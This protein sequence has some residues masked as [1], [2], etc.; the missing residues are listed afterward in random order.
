MVAA[1]KF[2]DRTLVLCFAGDWAQDGLAEIEEVVIEEGADGPGLQ[3]RITR[4]F[5]GRFLRPLPWQEQIEKWAAQNVGLAW[6]E[7]LHASEVLELWRLSL[8][9]TDPPARKD[10]RWNLLGVFV[11]VCVCPY[12]Y[13]YICIYV[14]MCVCACVTIGKMCLFFLG[15]Q[16][17][18]V[19]NELN[20]YMYIYVYVHLYACVCTT[21]TFFLF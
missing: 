10:T 15:F 19:A 7:E 21:V 17:Q 16:Q 9:G 8:P 18:D 3:E 11:F 2:E 1:A 4:R 6:D 20:E 5:A 14:Y 12:V 13:I